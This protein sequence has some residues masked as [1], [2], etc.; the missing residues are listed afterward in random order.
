LFKNLPTSSQLG[1]LKH[2]SCWSCLTDNTKPLLK[3][4][5]FIN[6]IKILKK[7]PE[8]KKDEIEELLSIMAGSVSD[9]PGLHKKSITS[10]ENIQYFINKG[11]KNHEHISFLLKDYTENPYTYQHLK[12][13]P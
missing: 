11:C 4:E 13:F 10:P 2:F 3:P 12:D 6:C 7:K 1:L 9:E 8:L 5:R